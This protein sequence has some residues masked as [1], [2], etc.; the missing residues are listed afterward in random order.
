ANCVA[1]LRKSFGTCRA[2]DITPDRVD[3]HIAARL[4][5]KPKPAKPATVRNEL[6]AL[7]RM[8]TLAHRAG[9][10]AVKPAFPT[11]TVDNARQGFFEEA[12]LRRVVAVLP[13]H[14]KPVA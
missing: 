3:A 2:V 7:K 9:K 1:H 4:G 10:V 8:F 13:K 14:L 11:L 12:D 6:A 5:A